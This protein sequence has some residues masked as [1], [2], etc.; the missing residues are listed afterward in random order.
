MTKRVA[1]VFRASI[2]LLFL[3]A[4]L[5]THAQSAYHKAIETWQQQRVEELKAED[6]WLNLTGL[7]WLKEGKNTFGCGKQ[8]ECIF[9]VGTIAEEAGYFER[10]GNIVNIVIY[11]S[12]VA[13]I[14]NQPITQ[15]LIYH[16]DS[17]KE[18]MVAI[19]NLRFHIISRGDKLGVRLRYLNNPSLST[20]KG[21]SHYTIDSS[22][23]I[24]ALFTPSS[25]SISIT[26]ILGQETKQ[27]SPGSISFKIAHNIYKLDVLEGNEQAYFILFGDATNKHETYGAGR[28]IYI[29]KPDMLGNTVIDFNKAYN[30]PCAYTPYATCPL[31]PKQNILLLKIEAGEKYINEH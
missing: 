12:V 21:I 20:F 11:K 22:W 19:S 27:R 1:S 24:Q 2:Y 3:V 14:N 29:T 28:F 17:L 16:S 30:P 6:G 9:P 23:R 25:D 18:V 4:S 7:F 31:P 10:V 5:N 13:T 26:N 8:N 15:A